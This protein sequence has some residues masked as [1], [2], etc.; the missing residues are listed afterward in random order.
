MSWR[1][2]EDAAHTKV[3]EAEDEPEEVMTE[4]SE[5][6]SH[7]HHGKKTPVLTHPHTFVRTGNVSRESVE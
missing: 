1:H 6:R 4:V 2:G 7:Q 5:A 3:S